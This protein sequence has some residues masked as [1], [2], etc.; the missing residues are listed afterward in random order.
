MSLAKWSFKNFIRG[1][2][3]LYIFFNVKRLPDRKRKVFE[4]VDARRR[5]FRRKHQIAHL[6]ISNY[7]GLAR[8][9]ILELHLL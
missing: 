5:F 4:V 3:K 1:S 6:L 2:S 8:I 9:K 7:A